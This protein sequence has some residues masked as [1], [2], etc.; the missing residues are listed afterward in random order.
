MCP[1]CT[2]HCEVDTVFGIGSAFTI[3]MPFLFSS[4]YSCH[5]LWH[6]VSRILLFLYMKTEEPIQFPI[7]HNVGCNCLSLNS[8]ECVNLKIK[9]NSH[10][11][12]EKHIGLVHRNAN[13]FSHAY[14]VVFSGCSL[15]SQRHIVILCA[16]VCLCVYVREFFRYMSLI[17][18][19]FRTLHVHSHTTTNIYIST[20][21]SHRSLVLCLKYITRSERR[22]RTI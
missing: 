11:H 1:V 5:I 13:N 2:V 9:H 14:Y 20:Q 21:T 15:N 3:E 17:V 4:G 19:S 10:T 22:Q 7:A 16:W 12:I 18:T 6:E 8:T